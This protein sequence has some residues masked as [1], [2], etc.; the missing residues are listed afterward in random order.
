[1]TKKRGEKGADTTTAVL[2]GA[3]TTGAAVPL[4]TAVVEAERGQRMANV[5]TGI[6]HEF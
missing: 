3:P 6:F 2:V 1:M 5:K 4:H